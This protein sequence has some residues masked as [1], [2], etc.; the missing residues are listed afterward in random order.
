M[1]HLGSKR[2]CHENITSGSMVQVYWRQIS[3]IAFQSR[4]VQQFV[5]T[6]PK[7]NIKV[8][9][10]QSP[11]ISF[12]KHYDDVIM[13][14]IASQITSLTIVYSTVYSDAD[15]RKYQRSAS[16]AFVQ[17]IHR[18]P[19]NSPHKW[20]VSRKMFPFHDVIMHKEFLCHEVIMTASK[21]KSSCLG[22]SV[23]N[24]DTNDA[25]WHKNG[26]GFWSVTFQF[27]QRFN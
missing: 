8:P 10:Y 16:L 15:Q 24:C 22:D 26:P 13:S 9:H 7:G 5:Q 4:F 25:S 2:K 11:V 20:P 23:H 6:N 19:V 1:L 12:T 17:G 3:V 18:G 27:R 14:A 21:I